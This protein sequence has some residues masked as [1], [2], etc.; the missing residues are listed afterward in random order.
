MTSARRFYSQTVAVDGSWMSGC[1]SC[2]APIE[3]IPSNSRDSTGR[4]SLFNVD[5]RSLN[6]SSIRG[7][8]N[9]GF[10]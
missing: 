7:L 6:I 5:I 9:G 3:V 4:V 8:L 10:S 1:L 2:Q